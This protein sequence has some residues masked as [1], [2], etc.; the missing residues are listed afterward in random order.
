[1]A[2]LPIPRRVLVVLFGHDPNVIADRRAALES[3]GYETVVTMTASEAEQYLT[4]KLADVLLVGS[5][6]GPLTRIRLAEKA[7]QCGVAVVHIA[8]HNHPIPIADE[9]YVTR[10]LG[11]SELLD[12]M[13]RALRGHKP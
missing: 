6:T 9:I 13:S 8:Y 12:A 2:A 1:M 4:S 7:R 10:P 11:A 3:V 5:Q